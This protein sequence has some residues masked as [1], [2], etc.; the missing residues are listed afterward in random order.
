MMRTGA[1]CLFW[2]CLVAGTARAQQLSAREVLEKV[3]GNY[4]KLTALHA[5][6][7]MEQAANRRIVVLDC[8][9]VDKGAR[10]IARVK[11]SRDTAILA[12]DGSTITRALIG[13]KRWSKISAAALADEDEDDA[14]SGARDL[15]QSLLQ[16]M[17]GT[18]VVIA[19]K[20]EDP[21]IVKETDFKLGREKV[22]CYV[23]RARTGIEEHE[24]LVDKATFLV[25]Q[26]KFKGR[27]ASGPVESTFKVR[28]IEINSQVAD[29]L[30]AFAPAPDWTEV[31]SLTLPGE[32]PMVLTG[33]RAPDFALQTLDGDQVS[34]SNLRGS[35]V[36]LDFWAT[37]CP[38]CRAEMPSIEKLRAEFG[39]AVEFLGVNNE[40]PATVRKFLDQQHY[41]LRVLTDRQRQVQ[42]RY[43]VRAIP[44]VVVIGR[45]GVVRQQFLGAQ[46]ESAL[47]KA[48]QSVVANRS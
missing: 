30:L 23:I 8:E 44:V 27:S 24:L 12:S 17:A 10:Y 15:H 16:M 39:D 13:M 22:R 33:E 48:I 3:R 36:V 32:Q 7:E 19:K 2:I 40:A 34:L 1:F 9:L 41:R 46:S 21:V 25:M 43:G 42:R 11:D 47:R 20:A 26:H 6:A 5:V 45:D 18:F 4:S 14:S 29:T 38:P 37:W 28:S 35:V 31:E